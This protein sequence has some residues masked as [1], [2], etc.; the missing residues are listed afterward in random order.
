M[1]IVIPIDG[2][3]SSGKSTVGFLFS[4]KIGFQFIDTGVIYRA[5]SLIA[6]R[7]GVMNLGLRV[8]NEAELVKIFEDMDILF[9]TIGGKV[10]VFLNKEDVTDKLHTPEVTKVVPAIGAVRSV[11]KAA[12]RIQYEIAQN[13]DTVMAG[14]DIGSE[15]FPGAPLKFFITALAEVR[16]KRRYEQHKA[17]LFVG[18][19]R[20][21]GEDITYEQILLDTKKRDEMDEKREASPMRVPKDAII[22]D[23][24]KK[25]I[26]EVVEELLSHYKKL[27]PS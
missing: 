16:A 19:N 15:I 6:L 25:N 3:S 11:R 13:Q 14:R 7:S 20:K 18:D 24:S 23:T 12:K 4:K 10:R 17:K 1:A 21:N 9:K 27:N 5:G 2:P 8:Q 22:I 26:D